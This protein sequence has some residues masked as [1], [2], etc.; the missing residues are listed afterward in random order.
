MLYSSQHIWLYEHYCKYCNLVCCTVV[1]IFGAN[2]GYHFNSLV[3]SL[4]I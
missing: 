1:S 3:C 4:A 2:I